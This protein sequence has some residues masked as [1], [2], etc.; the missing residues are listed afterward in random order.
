MTEHRITWPEHYPEQLIDIGNI[1][2]EGIAQ[3]GVEGDRIASLTFKITE[4]IRSQCGGAAFYLSRGRRYEL[5]QREE[6]IW[7]EFDGT[8]YYQLAK[9]YDL[10]EMQIRNIVK[11][12]KDRDR[13]LRQGKLFE[14]PQQN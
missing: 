13:A 10:S 5:S 2:A 1:I 7:R 11:R 12:A 6:K 4:N 3:T 9:Q 8:N 14:C